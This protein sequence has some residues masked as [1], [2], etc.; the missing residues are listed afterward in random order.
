MPRLAAALLAALVALALVALPA[1][2][3]SPFPSRI[4]LPDG[5]Q[6]EGI[7][8]GTGTTAYVGSLADGSIA[9]V[10]LRTGTVDPAFIEGQGLPAVGLFYEG[11]HDRLWAAGGPSGQVRVYDA[12]TGAAL[13]TYQFGA[14]FVND[15]VVTEHAAYATDSV[16]PQVLV[17]PIAEDG[18]LAAPSD[19]FALPIT[20]DFAYE[21]GFNANGI[22][23]W[24]GRLIVPQSNTG[25]LFAVDPATGD[26]VRLLPEGT[27]AAADGVRF[28]GANLY[29][30]R[31]MLNQ[32]DV[33]RFRGG[34]PDFVRTID[35]DGV[36]VPT[37]IAHGAGRLWVVNA[38]FG[39]TPTPDTP[40]WITQIPRA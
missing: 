40:Y 22:E 19:A 24:D 7:T 23:W 32:V 26:S 4:D 38:R 15:V 3:A 30:V 10:N 37:T 11:E 28:V 31:N 12:S 21:A 2:A 14:G 6:P 20:G 27:I 25:E 29:V 35:P 16:V 1:S 13:E 33:Y 17:I 36:D 8:A 18:T 34:T 39:T 9:R 5:W